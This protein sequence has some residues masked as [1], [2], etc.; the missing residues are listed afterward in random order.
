MKRSY[1]SAW[2]PKESKI[3][4]K[5]KITAC[6]NSTVAIFDYPPTSEY[7]PRLVGDERK[8]PIVICEHLKLGRNGI[9]HM[10]IQN[11]IILEVLFLSIIIY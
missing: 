9:F 4:K 7:I 1:V 11:L 10:P 2:F 5:K 6:E 8:L 3:A